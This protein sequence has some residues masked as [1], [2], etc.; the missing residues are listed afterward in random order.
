MVDE[1][2]PHTGADPLEA[3]AEAA[4]SCSVALASRQLDSLTTVRQ[5]LLCSPEI[6]RRTPVAHHPLQKASECL[7]LVP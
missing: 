2:D 5:E 4:R 3:A 7:T 6:V 1:V